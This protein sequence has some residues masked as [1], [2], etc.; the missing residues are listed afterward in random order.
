MP[1]KLPDFF[2]LIKGDWE[3]DNEEPVD[4]LFSDSVGQDANGRGISAYA[5]GQGLMAVP[6]KKPI[7]LLINSMGGS[8]AE[9]TAMCSMVASR[10]NVTTCV[11]GWAASMGA[12]LSQSG[13]KR[14]MMPGTMLVIHNPWGD[15]GAGDYRAMEQKA[16]QYKQVRDN[17]VEFLAEKTGN[18][19]KKIADMMD[20][21]TMLTPEQCKELGFCDEVVNGDPVWNSIE[22][23]SPLKA[24][25]NLAGQTNPPS[26]EQ[27]PQNKTKMKNIVAKLAML[28]LLPTSD[29]NDEG[30]IVNA[31]ETRFA[32]FSRL[33]AEN[34]TLKT[35]NKKFKDG[36]KARVEALVAK[37]ITD[38]VVKDERKQFLIDMGTNDETA[39][40]NYL[41]DVRSVKA[42]STGNTNGQRPRFG[43]PPV[44]I[45]KGGTEG[46]TTDDKIRNLQAQLRDNTDMTALER[47]DI[48]A[49]LRELRGRGELFTAEDRKGR[50]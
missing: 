6:R 16:E 44:P 50:P 25:K 31:L 41:D 28:N 3:A 22:K 34:E 18:S 48:C 39:L 12:I 38:K 4:I 47:S 9:G 35:E 27:E 14:K 26:T 42:E 32:P 2:K 5:F 10:G 23:P 1:K 20:A 43:A 45:K 46:E 49:Q 13:V 33:S 30:A 17:M 19:K 37:A 29:M 36:Q 24:L 15:P 40:V 21:E 8:V 7:N 11:I